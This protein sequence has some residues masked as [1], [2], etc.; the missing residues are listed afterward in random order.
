MPTYNF[1][2]VKTG[3]EWTEYMGIA[4]RETFLAEHPDVEQ[5]PCSPPI[6]YHALDSVKP[7]SGF[8]ELLKHIKKKNRGA[9]INDW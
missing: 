2:D 7:S 3:H 9:T 5:I 8:R 6:L 1:K 4:E